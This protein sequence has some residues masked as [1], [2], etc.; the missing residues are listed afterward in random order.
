MRRMVV[1]NPNAHLQ[2][3]E[4]ETKWSSNFS[5]VPVISCDGLENGYADDFF[6][7][8]TANHLPFNLKSTR[9]HDFCKRAFFKACARKG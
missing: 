9:R 7:Q 2:K 5:H 3:L 4:T 6:K 1:K 8:E